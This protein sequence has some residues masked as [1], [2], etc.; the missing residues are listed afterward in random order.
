VG[1]GWKARATETQQGWVGGKPGTAVPGCAAWMPPVHFRLFAFPFAS[2]RLRV[3]LIEWKV[4]LWQWGGC[5][6]PLTPGPSP[7][8][9]A[10]GA[11]TLSRHRKQMIL[12]VFR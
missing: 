12:V 10:R 6:L 1:S 11:V 4:M 8:P 2:S 5:L 9:G 7:L 3:R